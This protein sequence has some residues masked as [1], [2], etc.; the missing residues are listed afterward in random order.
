MI[1]FMS[2]YGKNP[3]KIFRTTT[4]KKKKKKKKKTENIE[5]V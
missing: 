1:A 3:K 4:K 5:T 2:I